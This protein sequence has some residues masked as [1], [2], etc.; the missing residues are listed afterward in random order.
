LF[1]AKEAILLLSFRLQSCKLFRKQKCPYQKE[2]E[3]V[4]L[5]P[6][7]L[8]PAQLREYENICLPCSEGKEQRRKS[9]R[10]PVSFL[11]YCQQAEQASI[12]GKAYNLSTDGVA[13]KTNY[14]ISKNEKLVME[15]LVPNRDSPFRMVGEVMWRQFHG[16]TK[17][18][19]ETLFSAGIKFIDIEA[20]LRRAIEQYLL[21]ASDQ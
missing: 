1:S 6:Q 15:F 17:G 10:L 7:L 8:D 9:Q 4:Y 12:V 18:Q 20:A 21:R 19:Q 5:I 13:L 14:P 3:R 11:V 16:D 2:I